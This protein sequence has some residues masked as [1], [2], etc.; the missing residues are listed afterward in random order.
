M[1]H[2]ERKCQFQDHVPEIYM[3]MVPNQSAES[4]V[5]LNTRLIKFKG[6]N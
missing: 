6:L 5:L 1:L 4:A 3:V 2:T